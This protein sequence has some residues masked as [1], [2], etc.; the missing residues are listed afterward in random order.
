MM[1]PI[2][3]ECGSSNVSVVCKVWLDFTDGQPAL[4]SN[5][6]EYAEPVPEANNALCRHCEHE[7]T[8]E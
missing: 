2:C 8:V 1:N 7:F 6:G 3:P 4:D 5:D